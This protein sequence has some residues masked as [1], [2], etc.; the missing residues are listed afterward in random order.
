MKKLSFLCVNF[1]YSWKPHTLSHSNKIYKYKFSDGKG[2]NKK[3]KMN[4]F[5]YL[6]FSVSVAS[7]SL[8]IW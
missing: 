7:R 6:N 5:Y 4:M 3:V 2:D 1:L 8:V